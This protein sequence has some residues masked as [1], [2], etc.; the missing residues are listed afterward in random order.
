MPSKSEVL[1]QLRAD[2]ATVEHGGREGSVSLRQK[3]D[4]QEPVSQD[5]CAKAYQRILRS[6]SVREQS[7]ARMRQKLAKDGY[8]EDVIEEALSRACRLRVIDDTR[9]SELLVRTTLAQGKGLRFALREIEELGVD[10]HELDAYEDYLDSATDEDEAR[11]RRVLELHPPRAK[12]KREAAY[13]KLM[14]KG[15]ASDVASRAARQWAETTE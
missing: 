14:A 1:A 3:P 11:A 10:P 4:S 8:A 7:T 12:N 15:F 2:I 9:Y 5:E 13:R 6:A